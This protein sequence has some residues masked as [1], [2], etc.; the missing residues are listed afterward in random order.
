MFLNRDLTGEL[1]LEE[2]VE[3]PRELLAEQKPEDT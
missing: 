3:T 2:R 1:S